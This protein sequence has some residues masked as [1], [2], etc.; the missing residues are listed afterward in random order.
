MKWSTVI[1]ICSM[2]LF[3]NTLAFGQKRFLYAGS[4]SDKDSTGIYVFAFDIKTG[5]ISE[6]IRQN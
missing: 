6:V 2:L 5:I 4:Y 3:F 1:S